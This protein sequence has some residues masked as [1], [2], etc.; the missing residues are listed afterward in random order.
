LTSGR[1]QLRP[2]KEKEDITS[3][4]AQSVIM[5]PGE[6][7]EYADT[8]MVRKEEVDTALYAGLRQHLLIFKKTTLTD[9]AQQVNDLFG[10]TLHF[11]PSL[12][13]Q[14]FPAKVPLTKDGLMVLKTIIAQS[15]D[16]RIVRET[17][18]AIYFAGK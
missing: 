6:L 11:P 9:V 2:E 15:F 18:Q 16:V 5:Q 8:K 1:V 13:Q 17:E 3:S 7:V 10:Y 4:R 12:G 14:S